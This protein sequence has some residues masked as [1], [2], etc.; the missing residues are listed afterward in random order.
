MP[1]LQ[2]IDD[3]LS[4]ID[5]L[6]AARAETSKRSLKRLL[7]RDPSGMLYGLCMIENHIDDLQALQRARRMVQDFRAQ[8]E[9]S[10]A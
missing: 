7:H 10:V 8:R 6:I 9:R 2:E 5:A 1:S 4:Q 3:A